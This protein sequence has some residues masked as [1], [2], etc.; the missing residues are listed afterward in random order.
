LIRPGQKEDF[1][2]FC[3]LFFF[4]P[5]LFGGNLIKGGGGFF[6]WG[7]VLAKIKDYKLATRGP[8]AGHLH[9]E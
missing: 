3:A 6:F 7:A 1:L 5:P 9:L 8:T 2:F 4:F